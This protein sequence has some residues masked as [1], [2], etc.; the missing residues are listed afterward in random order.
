MK[1]NVNSKVGNAGEGGGAAKPN[2]GPAKLPEFKPAK[3]I[4]EMTAKELKQYER[5]KK[6]FDKKQLRLQKIKDKEKEKVNPIGGFIARLIMS[7]IHG[8]KFLERDRTYLIIG[9]KLSSVVAYS[10]LKNSEKNEVERE[11]L[12]RFLVGNGY[13]PT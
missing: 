7:E 1:S 13:S 6:R 4:E 5:Q 12:S 11:D 8:L 10:L 3:P 9:R 2:S